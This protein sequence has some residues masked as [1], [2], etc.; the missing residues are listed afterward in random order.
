MPRSFLL[1]KGGGGAASGGLVFVVGSSA[2]KRL[3]LGREDLGRCPRVVEFAVNVWVLCQRSTIRQSSCRR[4]M[5][6]LFCDGI[7]L[8][9]KR[10]LAKQ[11]LQIFLGEEKVSSDGRFEEP[12]F[13]V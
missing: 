2:D 7:L 10:V 13:C 3:R 4:F 1:V 8:L 11:F 6:R 12:E 9:N 5:I